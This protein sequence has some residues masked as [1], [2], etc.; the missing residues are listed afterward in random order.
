MIPKIIFNIICLFFKNINKKLEFNND[1]I[2]FLNL[3]LY[4]IYN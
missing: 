1:K 2:I 4:L 3:N